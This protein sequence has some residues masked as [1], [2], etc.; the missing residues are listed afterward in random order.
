MDRLEQCRAVQD[1]FV[2]AFEDTKAEVAQLP[3]S[4]NH[5]EK[6]L[7]MLNRMDVLGE[8]QDIEAW[9]ETVTFQELLDMELLQLMDIIYQLWVS[10]TLS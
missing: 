8:S 2:V 3:G 5:W 10:A 9:L 6:V 1:A 7:T 4:S